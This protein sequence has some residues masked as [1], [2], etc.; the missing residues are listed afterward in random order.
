MNDFGVMEQA[1]ARELVNG[2][3]LRPNPAEKP[4][5]GTMRP[6]FPLIG[7]NPPTKSP[8]IRDTHIRSLAEEKR[9]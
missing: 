6:S 4:A 2:V 7:P 1:E 9:L 3:E 5:R 8:L